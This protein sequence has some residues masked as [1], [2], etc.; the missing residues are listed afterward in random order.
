MP[1][2][3]KCENCQED[4]IY[5][6]QSINISDEYKC[7]HCKHVG[8]ITEDTQIEEVEKGESTIR[9]GIKAAI[10]K[11]KID[12]P[13]KVI[14]TDINMSFGSMVSFMVKWVI[15]SIPAI[16]ILFMIGALLIGI[17]G[18]LALFG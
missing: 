2:K 4:I 14:V 8:K 17:F 10:A 6:H 15:A 11:S 16:I 9:K 7:S 18:G 1:Y 13:Q 5:M 12:P 3:F